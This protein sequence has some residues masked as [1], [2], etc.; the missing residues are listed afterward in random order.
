MEV[1]YPGDELKPGEV[2]KT[3]REHL[4]DIYARLER[5]ESILYKKEPPKADGPR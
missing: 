5:L 3:V 1:R 4:Q 2:G